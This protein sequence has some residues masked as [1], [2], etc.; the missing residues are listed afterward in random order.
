M[1]LDKT[2]PRDW[3]LL[4][5][6]GL[7]VLIAILLRPILPRPKRI[8]IILYGH[9][10]NGN[11][12][13]LRQR[14]AGTI[15][16]MRVEFLTM[17]PAYH[18][19]LQRD[20]IASIAAYSP[21]CCAALATASAVIADHGLHA[22]QLMVGLSDLKFFDVWH[23]I[24][25]K[26]FDAADFRFQ[27]G[28]DEIWVASPL[29]K[30]LYVERYGFPDTKVSVTGYA[31]TDRLVRQTEDKAELRARFGLPAQG[32]IVL[33]APTWVQDAR[34]RNIYPFGLEEES[35]LAALADMTSRHGATT[36]MRAHL[37]SGVAPGRRNARVIAKPQSEEPDTEGLLLVSDILICDWSSIAFDF[38]LLRR[39]VIFLDVLPPFRKGFSLGP[40]FRYGLLADEIQNL[41]DE[42]DTCLA[43][44][45][46][47]WAE[48]G[49]R[50]EAT[51]RDV[52]DRYAD[53]RSAE[54]CV[55][56]LIAR[57]N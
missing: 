40:E 14:I 15:P 56:R 33:F 11:L 55:E 8:R 20:G 53:G 25:F 3:L 57:L 34:D 24:P 4:L 6:Y 31:R 5:A 41:L 12:L 2:R 47:Y 13:V 37:N 22:M 28:Y 52:Y 44:S 38:L 54:R 16:D 32:Q 7:N 43:D 35:F 45:T 17:D 36:V 18:A 30:Q 42:L 49:D 46:R 21:S 9:K 10:L 27:Q 50:H 26:G 1:K 51:I 19:Q 39:P 23:G 29:H 48:A